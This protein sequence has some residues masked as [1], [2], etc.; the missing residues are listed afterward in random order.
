[1]YIV[2]MF[3]GSTHNEALCVSSDGSDN[4][5]IFLDKV[6]DLEEKISHSFNEVFLFSN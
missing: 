2:H 1:M 6:S 4:I 5:S 3:S